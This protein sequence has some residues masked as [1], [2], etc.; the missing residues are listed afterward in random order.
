MGLFSSKSS[1]TATPAAPRL[2]VPRVTPAPATMPPRPLGMAQMP[3]V[4]PPTSGP[5][6]ERAA[7]LQQLKVRI[8]AQLV[9]R[10]DMQNMRMLPPETVR[11]EVRILIRELC[12]SEKGLLN[13]SDQE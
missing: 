11:G 1:G 6:S 4:M 5:L 9:S 2:D 8:H 3:A 7:Y 10:L 13:S 12:Q